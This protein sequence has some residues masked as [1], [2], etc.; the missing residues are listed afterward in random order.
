MSWRLSFP[1]DLCAQLTDKSRQEASLHVAH[2]SLLYESW[3]SVHNTIEY[4][5][6]RDFIHQS[7][8]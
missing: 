6:C 2:Y 3:H 7:V 5:S 8:L 4:F 1:D